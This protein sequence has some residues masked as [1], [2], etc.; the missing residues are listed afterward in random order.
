[1]EVEVRVYGRLVE[2]L[3][4][5]S[6][7]VNMESGRTLRDLIKSL[8]KLN[9]SFSKLLIDESGGLKQGYIILVNGESVEDLGRELSEG[10]RVDILPPAV[11]GNI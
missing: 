6:I 8:D 3:N 7:K 5:T 9:P 2:V 4:V 11:G 10:D 1:V